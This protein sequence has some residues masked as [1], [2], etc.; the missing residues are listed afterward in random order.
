MEP[1]ATRILT[2]HDG[3]D[4]KKIPNLLVGDDAKYF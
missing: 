2:Y 1:I 4:E 3:G